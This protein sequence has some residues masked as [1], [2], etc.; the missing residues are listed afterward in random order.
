[1]E[2][3]RAKAAARAPARTGRGGAACAANG[4]RPL[5]RLRPAAGGPRRGGGARY[6]CPAPGGAAGPARPRVARWRARRWT[7]RWTCWWPAVAPPAW[8]AA[9][10]RSWRP[11][12]RRPGA[13]GGGG[14]GGG[15]SRASTSATRRAGSRA[16]PRTGPGWR[17]SRRDWRAWRSRRRGRCWGGAAVES[18][19]ALWAFPPGAGRPGRGPGGGCAPMWGSGGVP[20]MAFSRLAD[21][22]GDGHAG[23]G[24]A[25]AGLRAAGGAGARRAAPGRGDAA[26]AAGVPAAADRFDGEAAREAR[27]CPGAT[28]AGG[29]RSRGRGALAP[30]ERSVPEA[31]AALGVDAATIRRAIRPGGAGRGPA[32]RAL[33]GGPREPGGAAGGAGGMPARA[34]AARRAADPPGPPTLGRRASG[35]PVPPGSR[36]ALGRQRRRARARWAA[37][38][39]DGTPRRATPG[40]R[41]GTWRELC[42]PFVG[43]G[44][45]CRIGGGTVAR[46][47]WRSPGATCCYPTSDGHRLPPGDPH[48]G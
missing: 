10:G 14:A 43:S 37:W 23:G 22:S 32:G 42:L 1:M 24:G 29:G 5:R 18:L 17:N 31:A 46:A 19:A 2:R 12:R 15:S 44:A 41:T 7:R 28:R 47:R 11:T 34:P 6:V 30:G 27:G 13:R 8:R 40:T 21:G 38:I 35:V 4:H 26:L 3:I 20:G 48:P 25:A 9:I 33:R 45:P 16:W 36:Y 39:G